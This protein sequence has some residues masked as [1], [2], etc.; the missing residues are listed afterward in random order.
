MAKELKTLED[1]FHHQ[2]RDLYS[3]ETQL[4]D[5]LPEMAKKASN[6]QLRN[7]LNKHLEE[8][9][10]QKER[11]ETVCNKLEISPEGETCNAMQGL[12]KEA[13]DFMK[14]DADQDV[15]DAG[16]IADAQRVEHYEIAGYG[17]VCTYAERLGMN[18]IKDIL[19]KTLSEEKNADGK[20]KD[21]AMSNVNQKAEA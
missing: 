7:A 5:A 20:L 2:L 1:L 16:I 3:A 15:M 12:I 14:H 11:L 4:I 17:T 6:E 10:K 9:K 8:T 19:G 13:K 18:D 21:I